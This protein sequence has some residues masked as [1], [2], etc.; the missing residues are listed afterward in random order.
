M[1]DNGF[2]SDLPRWQRPFAWVLAVATATAVVGLVVAL[3]LGGLAAAFG[4]GREPAASNVVPVETATT[5]PP[6]ASTTTGLA[7]PTASDPSIGRPVYT[8][9]SLLVLY[10]DEVRTT[11]AEDFSNDIGACYDAYERELEDFEAQV[12]AALNSYV[13]AVTRSGRYSPQ[14]YGCHDDG[15]CL[16]D[17]DEWC[18]ESEVQHID[19]F[20]LACPGTAEAID[21]QL[22][23]DFQRDQMEGERYTDP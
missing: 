12:T 19:G 14:Q 10:D 6:L 17:Y 11:C 15:R 2:F 9:F 21:D 1:P 7:T 16:D 22:E 5:L 18:W 13:G 23:E 8:E 3:I 20:G 4:W